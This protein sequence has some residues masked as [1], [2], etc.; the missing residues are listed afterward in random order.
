MINIKFRD[1]LANFTSFFRLIKFCE[2]ILLR[3]TRIIDGKIKKG[4]EKK[5]K[6]RREREI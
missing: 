3:Y 2:N 4:I 6:K 1:M 5:A